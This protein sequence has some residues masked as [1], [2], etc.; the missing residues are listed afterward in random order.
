MAVLVAKD[1]RLRTGLDTDY[2]LHDKEKPAS[3]KM[4]AGRGP[5]PILVAAD[6]VH[7]RQQKESIA[8][9]ITRA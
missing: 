4:G 7:D 8:R 9:S 2:G 6:H 1:V 3:L 5:K